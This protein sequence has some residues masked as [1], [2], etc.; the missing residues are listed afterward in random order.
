MR[1]FINIYIKLL[2]PFHFLKMM[3]SINSN[4]ILS[5]SSNYIKKKALI[6]KRKF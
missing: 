6:L 3:F 4:L 5:T 1:K 2:I